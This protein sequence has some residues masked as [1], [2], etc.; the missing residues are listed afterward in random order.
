MYFRRSASERHITVDWSKNRNITY[1]SYIRIFYLRHP[2]TNQFYL[3][4]LTQLL[5]ILDISPFYT[6]FELL[7]SKRTFVKIYLYSN[8]YFKDAI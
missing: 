8:Y 6:N 5:D 3:L 4:L 7:Y 1:R 2:F